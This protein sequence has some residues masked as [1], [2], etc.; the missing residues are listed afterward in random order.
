VKK[1]NAN[2]FLMALFRRNY[3]VALHNHVLSGQLAAGNN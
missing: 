3:G 2:N 1:L